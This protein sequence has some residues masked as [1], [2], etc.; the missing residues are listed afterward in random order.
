MRYVFIL[1]MLMSSSAH[2]E[3]IA[4]GDNRYWKDAE[5]NT[6]NQRVSIQ[7]LADDISEDENSEG[8]AHKSFVFH[9]QYQCEYGVPTKQRLFYYA[10]YQGRMATGN[11]KYVSE[12]APWLPFEGSRLTLGAHLLPMQSGK[13]TDTT[14]TLKT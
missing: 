6:D 5:F 9:M 7:V 12:G 8:T 3:W 1:I 10:F 2:A 14:F 4:S 13:N 11:V